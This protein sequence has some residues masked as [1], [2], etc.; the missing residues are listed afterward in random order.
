MRLEPLRPHASSTNS[1]LNRSLQLLRAHQELHNF[2]PALNGENRGAAA[3]FKKRSETIPHFAC[4]ETRATKR[5]LREG[6]PSDRNFA[7]CQMIHFLRNESNHEVV[8][9]R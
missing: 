7:E 1:M 4:R 2:S 9:R 8:S 6:A 5:R 3:S